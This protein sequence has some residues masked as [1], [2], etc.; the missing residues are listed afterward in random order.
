MTGEEPWATGRA[1]RMTTSIR[2]A[3]DQDRGAVVDLWRA[4][5]L[6]RPWND[7]PADFRAALVN[8]S[9]TVLL[10]TETG[11]ALRTEDQVLATVLAGY[12]GH[13]GWLYYLAVDPEH[14]GDGHGR[15]LVT[16]A[17]EWLAARGAVMVQLMV[18]EG[19]PAADFYAALGY[20]PQAVTTW[21][22]RLIE[23]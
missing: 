3:T 6:T 16:A 1:A 20:Q 23:H 10:L 21:G 11:R 2:D 18:R 9:S 13:R 19:N 5:D 4:C 7:P 17:E 8:P 14:R 15:A 12:D 22:R